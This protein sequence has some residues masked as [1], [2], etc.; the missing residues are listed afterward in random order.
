LSHPHHSDDDRYERLRREAEAAGA[1]VGELVRRAIDRERP[2][3]ADDRAAAGARL[4]GLRPPPAEGPQTD[5]ELQKR[6]LL[7]GHGG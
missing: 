1:P 4:L 7:D 5:W 3:G 2:A 6:E